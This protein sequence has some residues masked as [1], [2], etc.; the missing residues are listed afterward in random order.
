MISIFKSFG[1]RKWGA[2]ESSRLPAAIEEARYAAQQGD[3]WR[4]CRLFLEL[5]NNNP[6]PD[7]AEEIANFLG[8]SSRFEDVIA[9]MRAHFDNAYY[10]ATNADVRSATKDGDLH[11]LLYGW[12]EGRSPSQL[13]DQNYYE[14]KAVGL[15]NRE[16]PLA[17]YF[18]SSGEGKITPN[19]ISDKLWFTPNPPTDEEL[20]I[21]PG[22]RLD[23]A[24]NCVVVIPV[25]KGYEET[26][27]CVYHAL[28]SRRGAPYSILVVND[29]GPDPLLNAKLDHMAKRGMF[30][31]YENEKNLGFVKTV[32]RAIVDLSNNLDVILLNSDAYVF[33]GWFSRIMSHASDPSVATVTPLSNNATICSY[34][35]NNSDNNLALEIN[36]EDLDEL[37]SQVNAGGSVD[38][39]TGVGFCFYMRR[40][41]I[42]EIGALDADSFEIGYGEENDFCMRAWNA[43]YRNV[44]ATDVFVYHTGSVSFAGIKNENF[45]KGQQALRTKHPNYPRLVKYHLAA[46]PARKFR[47]ALDT[48]RVK[49]ALSGCVLFVT[50]KWSGG[51]NTYLDQKRA[52]FEAEGVSCVSLILH[53]FHCVTIEAS[54][55]K[56]HFFP[57]LA[58]I[59]L[60]TQ[61]DFVLDT[62][63]E[64][65]PSLVHINSLAGLSWH[66]QK[67][68]LM[69]LPELSQNVVFIGHDYA[70]ISHHYDLFRPDGIYSGVPSLAE[71][72][73]WA[74]SF[75]DPNRLDACSPGERHEVYKHFFEKVKRVEVPSESTKAIY[76]KEFPAAPIA[77]IPHDDHLPAIKIMER[78][79][80]DGVLRIA[81]V[82]AI[83][84]NKGSGVIFDLAAEIRKRNLPIEIHVVG[85][86]NKD[87]ELRS[88]GVNITGRYRREMQAVEYL[89]SIKPDLLFIPSVWPETFC[90]T[91]SLAIKMKIPPVVFDLGAQAERVKKLA[92]GATIDLECVRIPDR[93][94]K[95]IES[96]PVDQLWQNRE[97]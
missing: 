29:K 88:L 5:Y 25:Y 22:A 7:L 21:L 87:E 40:S 36:P 93:L 18:T 4:A 64:I 43:G 46:N 71:R 54:P 61:W 67:Q 37:T 79:K 72:V 81:V 6:S 73:E 17:H 95:A 28:K 11:Y 55:G 26:I 31:Y 86:S 89:E 45:E 63:R 94:V 19:S 49:R 53:D 23:N 68:F 14:K 65:T 90:Y 30:D 12:K 74:R 76:E 35:I 56:G 52:L 84:P 2:P 69:Y 92:W 60:R 3:T 1:A 8:T 41:V 13:F 16:F 75:D 70:P 97:K 57:N 48:S 44:L 58:H 32:N 20:D 82:G 10:L 59:D 96:I 42:D 83:G 66:W 38:V 78:R 34:P 51:I 33:D 9:A 27:T 47:Q 15:R 24:T 85:Y 77:V 39:P 50:H 80:S 91:L 62:L